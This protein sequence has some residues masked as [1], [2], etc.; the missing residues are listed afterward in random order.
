MTQD[1]W[2]KEL[3]AFSFGVVIFMVLS[4]NEW[5]TILC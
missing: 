2:I 4:Q 5:V 1:A 3:L